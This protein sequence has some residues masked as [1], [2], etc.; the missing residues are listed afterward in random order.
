MIGMPV[1]T[2]KLIAFPMKNS[3]CI[4]VATL[5]TGWDAQVNISYIN[6]SYSLL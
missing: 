3:V 4:T 6:P 1:G 2:Y 5:C